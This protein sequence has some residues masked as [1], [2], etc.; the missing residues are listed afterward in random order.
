[1]SENRSDIDINDPNFWQ[2]W[3]KKA[4]VDTDQDKVKYFITIL[5][6]D[7]NL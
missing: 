5:Y 1:M 3:A 6:M 4:D 2:K 7:Q